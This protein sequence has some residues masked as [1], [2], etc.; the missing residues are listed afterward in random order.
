MTVARNITFDQGTDVE[1]DITVTEDGD[2]V[3]LTTYS[4]NAAFRRHHESANSQAFN[5][6]LYANGVLRLSLSEIE[7]ANASP[8]TYI[9]SV[10]I[11][12]DSTLITTK[13]QSGL[14]VVNPGV[15]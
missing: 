15:I 2:T 11:Q 7:S 1:I 3:D 12:H 10:N 6:T 8:G 9:Y 14:L 13:I 4:A 5:T